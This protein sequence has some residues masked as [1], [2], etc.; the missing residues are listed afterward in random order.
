M[1]SFLWGKKKKKTAGF[2]SCKKQHSALRVSNFIPW[3]DRMFQFS[4]DSL[5]KGLVIDSQ[6]GVQWPD[7]WKKKKAL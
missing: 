4:G 3:M 5:A 7:P 6:L 2:A 1:K